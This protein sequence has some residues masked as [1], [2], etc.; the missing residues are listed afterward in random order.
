M[1][2]ETFSKMGWMGRTAALC[3]VLAA[4]LASGALLAVAAGPAEATFA[5]GNGKVAFTRSGDVWTMNADGSGA[6]KLTTN[7]NAEA[8]P[9]ISSD[10]SRIAYEFLRGIWVMNADGSGQ[11]MLTD[12]ATTDE[13]PSWSADGTRISFS[14]N[15]DLWSMNADGSAQANLTNTSNTQ[16]FDAAW[17]PLGDRIAYTRT[18]SIWVM[19]TDGSG[20]TNITPENSLP[21]CQNSPGYFHNGASREPSWSP[22]GQKIAYSGSLICPHVFGKDIW[23]MNA[24]GSGKTNLINDEGTGDLKPVFSPDGTKILFESNRDNDRL[25]LYA[26]GSGGSGLT[27]LTDNTVADNDA[28]WGVSSPTCDITGNGEIIGTAGDDVICGGPNN[29]TIDGLGGNDVILG[30][31]GNDTLVGADGRDTLNGGPG[32]DTA[33]F[34]GSTEAVEA[35]LAG[36]FAQ[37]VGTSPLEGVALVGIENV[38]GSDLG[39]VLGGSAGANSLVGGKGADELLGLAGNDRLTSKDGA[40]N[41]TVNGGGGNDRCVTDAR[42]AS[43]RGCE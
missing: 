32:V 30:G 16:E 13:D 6:T 37:K 5:G 14:R 2:K 9:T 35:S 12:G 29:D 3:M 19:N 23:T 26:M 20:Q 17:S 42:E 8:N 21:Q 4:L 33:S 43:I 40:K 18:S 39:D 34:A 1:A 27:R 38:V 25:E 24:D 41:D 7:Y 11:K 31:A 28:D 15:G 22:D 36:G 10:G